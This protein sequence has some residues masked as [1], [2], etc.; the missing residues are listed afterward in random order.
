MLASIEFIHRPGE[1]NSAMM[2][3]ADITCLGCQGGD[4]GRGGAGVEERRALVLVLT[5]TCR[6][7]PR[8]GIGGPQA[9][10]G[11]H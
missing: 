7:G 9:L 3:L 11:R 10:D 2:G 8:P 6:G 5:R 1:L 4:D